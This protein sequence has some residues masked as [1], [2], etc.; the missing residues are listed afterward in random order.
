MAGACGRSNRRHSKA[1]ILAFTVRRILDFF[2]W[3]FLL[4]YHIQKKS[5]RQ[6]LS[7]RI[8]CSWD[9]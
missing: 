2:L 4:I 3:Q 8:I 1:M 5:M 7:K 9:I 6:T